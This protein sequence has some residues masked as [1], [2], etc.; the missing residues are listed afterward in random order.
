MISWEKNPAHAYQKYANGAVFA[1][2]T[3]STVDMISKNGGHVIG[4]NVL[5]SPIRN[6]LINTWQKIFQTS[7]QDYNK[8]EDWAVIS[9]H[10][11]FQAV[12]QTL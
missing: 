7:S 9:F 12:S 8:F 6:L 1:I 3:N 11:D 2:F 10:G 5:K 4:Y